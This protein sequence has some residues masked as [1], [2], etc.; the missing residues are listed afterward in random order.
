MRNKLTSAIFSMTLAFNIFIMVQFRLIIMQQKENQM[1][2]RGSF[3][4]IDTTDR[5]ALTPEVMDPILKKY[6]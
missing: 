3:P 5:N 6:R 1:S 4:Y 2:L